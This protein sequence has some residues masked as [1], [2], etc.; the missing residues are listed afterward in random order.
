M[1]TEAQGSTSQVVAAVQLRLL[2]LT[3]IDHRLSATSQKAAR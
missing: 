2:P 1:A 3:T